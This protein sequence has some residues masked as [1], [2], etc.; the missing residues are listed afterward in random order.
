MGPVN[1]SKRKMV[2]CRDE[3]AE[4]I[5]GAKEEKEAGDEDERRR[6]RGC[7]LNRGRRR[8]RGRERGTRPEKCRIVRLAI[9]S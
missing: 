3:A 9:S 6:G 5:S 8:K 1:G 4:R 2:S 7:E